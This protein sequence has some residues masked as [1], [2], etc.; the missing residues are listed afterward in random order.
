MPTTYKILRIERDLTQQQVERLTGISQPTLSQI[1]RGVLKAKPDQ[2][3]R[4]A[5]VY[6]IETSEAI[7]AEK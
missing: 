1:E 3:Q 6:G 4:L 2:V 5:E 7:Q